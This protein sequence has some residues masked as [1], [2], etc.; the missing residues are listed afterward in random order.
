MFSIGWLESVVYKLRAVYPI[1]ER[2]AMR[3]YIWQWSIPFQLVSIFVGLVTWVYFGRMVGSRQEFIS[4]LIIGM[5]FA[6]ILNY[7]LTQFYVTLNTLY[8][9]GW[10]GGGRMSIF[11]YLRLARL[12]LSIYFLA[13]FLWRS[14]EQVIVVVGYLIFG[15]VA[16]G[17]TIVAPISGYLTAML[18]L[19]LGL[20]ATSGLGLISASMFWLADCKWGQEPIQWVISTLVMVTAGVYFQPEL[21]PPFL[22]YVSIL[23]PQRYVL[24][25]IRGALLQGQSLSELL[26]TVWTLCLFCIILLPIGI[27]MFRYS[28]RIG[29]KKVTII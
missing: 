8:F 9:S 24:D 21:L 3:T 19:A 26:P 16:F 4:Y 15:Y 1:V 23:L 12:P 22:R 13:L 11:D 10:V 29:E 28:L 7:C 25:G 5:A 14:L 27:A 6:P 17:L 20:L 18:L 2:Q